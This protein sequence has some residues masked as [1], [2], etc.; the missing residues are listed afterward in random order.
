MSTKSIFEEMR[1]KIANLPNLAGV[2]PDD[3][4]YDNY[5]D[6]LNSNSKM[7]D[8]LHWLYQ[9]AYHTN[10]QR[11][12]F[13]IFKSEIADL[14]DTEEIGTA[15][16]WERIV[17]E[18]QVFDQP[19][20]INGKTTYS[21]IDLTARIVKRVAVKQDDNGLV[22]IKVAKEDGASLAPLDDSVGNDEIGSLTSYL[23]TRQ[24]FGVKFN[25]INL[26]ADKLS[27]YGTI[28]YDPVLDIDD[29]TTSVETAINN[30]MASLDYDGKVYVRQLTDYIQAAH[31]VLDVSPIIINGKTGVN[32]TTT[33]QSYETASGYIIEDPDALFLDTL[34]FTPFEQ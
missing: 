7:A 24:P 32:V 29:V 3:Q 21:P 10:V 28:F 1:A 17:S 11:V 4:S 22:I 16:W 5:I 26:P 18:F 31:G 13:D 6:A 12:M 34:N 19:V 2:L 15:A 23:Q 33:E 9:F 20:V 27:V 25:L 30:Y 8:Y 14:A